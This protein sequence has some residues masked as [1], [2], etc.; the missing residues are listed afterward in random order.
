MA[1]SWN[2]CGQWP[3]LEK[4]NNGKKLTTNTKVTYELFNKIVYALVY[5]GAGKESN[6]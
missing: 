1:A 2:K 4:V 5:L 3:E 6:K